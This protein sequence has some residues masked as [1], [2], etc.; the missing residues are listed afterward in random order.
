MLYST[1]IYIHVI[2]AI[3]SIGPF[4]VLFPILNKMKKTESMDAFAAY[5]SAFQLGVTVVKHAGHLLVI[6]GLLAVWLG[7]W[8]L[9]TPWVLTTLIMLLASV[10]YLARAF[11]PTIKKF[12]IE[13]FEKIQFVNK[14]RQGVVVYTFLLLVMLWLMVVKP[15]LW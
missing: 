10:V 7:P 5:V 13:K 14:L 9:M 8:Q 6:F 1:V 11:K 3:L 12:G 4:F 15:N 2:S